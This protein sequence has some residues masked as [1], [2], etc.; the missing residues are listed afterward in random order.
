MGKEKVVVDTNILISS[1]LKP[2]SK[3]KD[4]YRLILRGKVRL[5]LSEDILAELKRVLEYPKFQIE[6]LQRHLFLKNLLRVATLVYPKQKVGV[7]KQD[8]ADNKFLECALEAKASF[9]VSGDK[10]HLLPLKS[11]RGIRIVSA[12]QFLRLHQRR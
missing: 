7:V 10:R 9:I 5:Y 3:A 2:E 6:R 4:I 8:P 12:A 1:L 11:F